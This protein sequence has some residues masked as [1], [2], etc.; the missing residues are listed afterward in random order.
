MSKEKTNI[1]EIVLGIVAIALLVALFVS[2][3]V[4]S[5]GEAS[6]AHSFGVGTNPIENYVPAIKFNDGYYSALGITTTGDV[7]AAAA[8]FSGAINLATAT[9]SG[10][11]TVSGET[12]LQGLTDGSGSLAIATS[13]GTTNITAAQLAAD[14]VFEITVND[15]ATASIQW[16]ATSTMSSLFTGESK[17]RSWLFHN[18]TTSTMAMTFLAGTGIDFIGVTTNDDVIDETE[19]SEFECWM[20]IST[21]VACRVSELLHID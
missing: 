6:P 8:T 5:P 16:P 2:G 20:K 10:A 11:L 19:Y 3:A 12:D 13:T 21:D 18:A 14:S 9:L 4:S 1:S 7:T 17:H 15:G